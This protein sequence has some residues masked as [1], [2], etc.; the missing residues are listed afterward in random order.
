MTRLH[1]GR[2]I[3]RKRFIADERGWW[4]KLASEEQRR[5]GSR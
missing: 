1:A 4:G 3:L 5:S 2:G